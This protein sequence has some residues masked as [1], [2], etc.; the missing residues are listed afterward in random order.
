[1]VLQEAMSDDRQ[2]LGVSSTATIGCPAS[3]DVAGRLAT[4]A[5]VSIARIVVLRR[6]KKGTTT[7]Q[8]AGSQLS[9]PYENYSNRP[10]IRCSQRAVESPAAASE[11]LG[12][13]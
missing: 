1:M 11:A 3:S 8:D 12:G 9:I 6:S 10:V 13:P 7:S 2:D 4:C 5:G